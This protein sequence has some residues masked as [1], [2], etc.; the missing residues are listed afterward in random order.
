MAWTEWCDRMDWIEWVG[1][2][3]LRTRMNRIEMQDS[4]V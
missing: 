2:A 1:Q 4:M 3:P